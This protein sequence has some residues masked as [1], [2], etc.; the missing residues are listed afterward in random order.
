M[1]SAYA[2][3]NDNN[4]TVSKSVHTLGLRLLC[5]FYRYSSL[6]Q[7]FFLT[8]VKILYEIRSPIPQWFTDI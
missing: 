7:L 1:G 6:I 5:I 2:T 3:K 4:L 8:Q